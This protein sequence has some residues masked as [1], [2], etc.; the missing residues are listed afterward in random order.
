MPPR[1]GEESSR[2]EVGDASVA[3]SVDRDA[4]RASSLL[5]E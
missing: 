5:G 1:A 2:L 4:P 3:W